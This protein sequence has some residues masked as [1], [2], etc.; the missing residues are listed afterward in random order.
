MSIRN[1]DPNIGTTE[2]VPPDGLHVDKM[3]PSAALSVMLDNQASAI[4]ALQ[5]ALPAIEAAAIAAHDR[6]SQTSNGRLIYAGAG[7]SARIGVQDG[8]ELPPTFNWP[9]DRLSFLIAGGP[10]ARVSDR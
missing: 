8:T 3:A 6:L 5:A 4:P 2:D 1:R 10:S 7:T 9:K